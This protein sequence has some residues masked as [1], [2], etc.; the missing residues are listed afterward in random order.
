MAVWLLW[1]FGPI[2]VIVPQEKDAQNS[3][4][5]TMVVLSMVRNTVDAATA[6][7]TGFDA[8]VDV[9]RVLHAMGC[10]KTPLLRGRKVVV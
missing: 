3:K 6:C 9:L 7:A 4:E 2:D 5:R 10:D 1:S 8:V